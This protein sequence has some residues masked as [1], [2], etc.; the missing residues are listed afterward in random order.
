[1]GLG[2]VDELLVALHGQLARD[3]S[4]DMLQHGGGALLQ[5]ALGVLKIGA[6]GL[7]AGAV[8]AGLVAA[9][10]LARPAPTGGW[11]VLWRTPGASLRSMAQ[12]HR[13]FPLLNTPHAFIGSLQDTLT[14]VAVAAW[15]G[16]AAAG[17]WRAPLGLAR[18]LRLRCRRG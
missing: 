5:L 10:V 13:D 17:L 9:V 16:D 12:R 18:R 6:A 1:M 3:L 11:A 8:A 14:L 7:L 2:K 15:S 4:Q